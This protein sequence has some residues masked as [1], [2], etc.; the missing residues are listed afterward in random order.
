[1][2]K[3]TGVQLG[4][5]VERQFHDIIDKGTRGGIY[6]ISKKFARTKNKYL[7]D[8]NASMPSKYII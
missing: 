1:M 7:E 6:C 4:L 3:M 5:M 2:L 8:Y